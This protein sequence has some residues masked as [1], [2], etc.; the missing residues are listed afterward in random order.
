MIQMCRYAALL[1]ARGTARIALMCHPALKT[2]F[3]SLTCVDQV[4]AYDE[5]LPP[6]PWD[7]WT[8]PFSIAYYCQTRID[9]IPVEIPYLATDLQRYERWRGVMAGDSP[10]P[11]LAVGLVWKGS[12]GFEND[13]DRSLPH[14]NTLA[15]L[16]QISQVR[17]FSLQKG[18]GEDEAAN[19]PV[20]LPLLDL[21]PQIVDFADSAAIITN[22]DLVI[23]V[24]TAIAH[25]AGA[26]G[27]ECWVLL[28]DYQTDWR[29]L[30]NRSDSPWYPSLR[31]FRQPPG[32]KWE[33]VIA[34]LSLALA[35]LAASHCL[36]PG[37]LPYHGGADIPR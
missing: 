8:P 3:N 34:T 30:K 2:L 26:L 11:D 28:P 5:T 4:F 31:L 37:C 35:K 32:E 18:A 21:G 20:G 13:A 16:G 12:A 36:D 29:W 7:F 15:P 25:L 17:F 24:D 14:L 1:K 27:K 10:C 22:L 6:T 23:C 33:G 19:P 9:S